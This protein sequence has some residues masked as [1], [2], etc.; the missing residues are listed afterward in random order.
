ME[1][2]HLKIK[3]AFFFSILAIIAFSIFRAQPSSAVSKVVVDS[4]QL[5]R[6][7]IR[8]WIF[9]TD[10]GES[11][12]RLS[13]PT[14]IS[15]QALLRR[16][17]RGNSNDAA[18]LDREVSSAYIAQVEPFVVRLLHQSRWLNAVSAYIEPTDLAKVAELDCVA[19]IRTVATYTKSVDLSTAE[20]LDKPLGP[21]PPDYGPSWTQ[22]NQIQVPALHDLGYK[23]TGV[24]ILMLDTGFRIN[25][26]V[27]AHTDIEATYDFINNDA[28]VDDDLPDSSQPIHGT[29]TF[30][31]IGASVEGLMLG[32]A[33][34]ATFLLAKT[35]IRADEIH[36][37][38]DN[39]VAAIEWGEALGCDVASSSLGYTDWY[40]YSDFDGNTA[41]ITKAADIAASLGVI[42]VN[43]AGNEQEIGSTAPSLIAPSDGDSV[44]SVGAVDLGG[45]IASFSSHGP[46][47]DGRIKPDLCALGI[48]NA[49]AN[50]TGNGLMT[51]SGTSFSCPLVAGTVALLLQAKPDWNYGK[52]YTA[53]TSTATRAN[54]PDNVYGYGIVRS[55]D[56]LNY[57]NGQSRSIVGIV[58]YPN[59]FAHAVRFDFEVPPV[60][61]VEIRIYTIAGEKIATL[62]RS[63]GDPAPIEWNGKNQ[64]DE[65]AA[66]GIYI[67]Y[68]SADG[69]SEMKKIVK[70]GQ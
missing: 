57:E 32:V 38:E 16:A 11:A 33:Y 35:E 29:Q 19:Q 68:I 49:V 30:S 45:Q 55:L 2:I 43:S 60:G 51:S 65:E 20:A 31:I 25:H 10:K 70:T 27:F 62:S 4:R 17:I 67:A 50:P 15:R 23:G 9:F 66:V 21:Y 18:N 12:N 34:D 28:D 64:D 26:P 69:I 14:A 59:P 22:M 63:A 37:E 58:A 61:E 24:R 52:I 3:F 39:W 13:K 7:S 1:T 56:A 8:V 6:D 36:A 44:I 47:Y 5:D 48:S 42:V 41:V 40:V 54:Y 53:L 46:S